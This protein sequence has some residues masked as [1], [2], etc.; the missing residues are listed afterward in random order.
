[1]LLVNANQSYFF[2]FRQVILG[3][4]DLDPMSG[5]LL[6]LN[7]IQTLMRY[8]YTCIHLYIHLYMYT[9]YTC[10]HEYMYT[11]IHYI[12]VYIYT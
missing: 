2:I 4:D 8:I 12:H 7:A 1:M 9:M 3:Y 11:C 6:L 10:I 5:M